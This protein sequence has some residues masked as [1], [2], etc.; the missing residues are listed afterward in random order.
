METT[1]AGPA[2]QDKALLDSTVAAS[3]EKAEKASEES[4][5]IR[6]ST[7]YSTVSVAQ[8]S[9]ETGAESGEG[10]RGG[11]CCTQG[12]SEMAQAER[13]LAA[14]SEA[15]VIETALVVRNR[16]CY[17]AVKMPRSLLG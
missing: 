4:Y 17:I 16:Q 10:T 14:R 6:Y 11:R 1:G 12:R 9:V 8:Q 7:R 3:T 15:E 13:I 5:A 2:V